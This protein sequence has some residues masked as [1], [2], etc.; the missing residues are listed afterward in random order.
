M[1]L[2]AAERMPDSNFRRKDS[3]N[4]SSLWSAGPT[5][6][7]GVEKIPIAGLKD[8]VGNLLFSDGVAD[9]HRMGKFVGVRIS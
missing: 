4:V 2:A 9:L 7:D 6:G 8:D 1:L 5:V 3:T